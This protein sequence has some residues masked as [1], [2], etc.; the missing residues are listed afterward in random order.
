MEKRFRREK[1]IISHRVQKKTH[2]NQHK[3]KKADTD[4][5]ENEDE[6]PLEH[7]SHTYTSIQT[8]SLI[9]DTVLL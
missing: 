2:E 5:T 9:R 1:N 7:L 4:T 6:S 8:K 3:T